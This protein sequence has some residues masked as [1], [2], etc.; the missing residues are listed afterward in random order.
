MQLPI[1]TPAETLPANIDNY[2]L[3]VGG[4]VYDRS[5]IIICKTQYSVIPYISWMK[6]V[7]HKINYRINWLYLGDD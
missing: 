2:D 5:Y 1:S 4:L 3:D 6:K 7:P